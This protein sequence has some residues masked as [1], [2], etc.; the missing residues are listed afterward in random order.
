MNGRKQNLYDLLGVA[1]DAKQIDIVRSYRK[2]EAEMR[3]EAAAPN[4]RR[5]ALI[6]GA[7]E[8]LSDPQRREAYDES[9]RGPSFLGVPGGERPK[10]KWGLLVAGIAL[11]LG[12]LYYFTIG[13]AP[14]PPRA[15]AG[16]SPQEVHTAAAVSV[17]RVDRIEISGARSRLGTAVAVEEGVMMAPCAGIGPGIQ[18]VVRIPPR[19]IPAQ[20]RQADEALGLCKLQVSGGASWPLPMTG[21]VP[22]VGDTVYAANLDALGNVVISPGEVKKITRGAHGHLIDSTARAG[23]PI[24]GSPLLD[25]EGR[26]VAVALEGQH[27]TLPAAWI[28]DVPRRP[29]PEPRP[30]EE[31]A[32]ETPEAAGARRLESVSPDRRERL[33]KAFRPPPSV[34]DDL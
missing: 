21:L 13:S 3:S 24:D 26:I 23:P 17:G 9:L 20:L 5:A 33:E 7:Y 34:P 2:L 30:P 25:V 29:R 15:G 10:R 1:R 6:H 4:P 22:G 12:A 14:E 18:I 31:A 28:V 16:L 27:N 11:V 19:D 8:V 32:P